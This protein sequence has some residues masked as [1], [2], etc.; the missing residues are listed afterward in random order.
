MYC[1]LL[2]RAVVET[3][4]RFDDYLRGTGIDVVLGPSAKLSE[5]ARNNTVN[6][7]KFWGWTRHPRRSRFN[8]FSEVL[9]YGGYMTL[10][11]SNPRPPHLF[12]ITCL[13]DVLC[14][15]VF[16]INSADLAANCRGPRII[17]DYAIRQTSISAEPIDHS[18]LKDAAMSHNCDHF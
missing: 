9:R 10:P 16:P 2:D 3:L 14:V 6:K 1:L 15:R 5:L 12:T 18:R 8:S 11:T 13:Y 7:R 17:F 4:M